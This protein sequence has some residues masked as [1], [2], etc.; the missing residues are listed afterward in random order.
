MKFNHKLYGNC[1]LMKNKSFKVSE[2]PE[3]INYTLENSMIIRDSSIEDS[4]IIIT[5]E[6]L[7]EYKY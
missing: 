2:T 7:K 4:G 5:R 6:K 1:I 3:S